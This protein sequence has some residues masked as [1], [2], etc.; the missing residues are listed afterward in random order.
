MQASLLLL[1][2]LSTTPA[3]ASTAVTVLDCIC[4]R[5]FDRGMKVKTN[6]MLDPY[7]LGVYSIVARTRSSCRG[8]L[9]DDAFRSS[10]AML[11]QMVP[12]HNS[13]SPLPSEEGDRCRIVEGMRR[14]E[15]DSAKDLLC[16]VAPEVLD[17]EPD[18][19]LED[20]EWGK[21]L[22]HMSHQQRRHLLDELLV[23]NVQLSKAITSN[24]ECYWWSGNALTYNSS[25]TDSDI[26]ASFRNVLRVLSSSLHKHLQLLSRAMKNFHRIYTAL[27]LQQK[28]KNMSEHQL[29]SLL[30]YVEKLWN[31]LHVRTSGWLED[32][33]DV[34]D[35]LS[36]TL[37]KKRVQETAWEF[38]I[39][40]ALTYDRLLDYHD[41]RTTFWEDFAEKCEKVIGGTPEVLQ[42]ADAV[43]TYLVYKWFRKTRVFFETCYYFVGKDHEWQLEDLS[44]SRMSVDSSCVQFMVDLLDRPVC[45]L[46]DTSEQT[47]RK[48]EACHLQLGRDLMYGL[49]YIP[50]TSY[51]AYT[52][53]VNINI[54][55]LSWMVISSKSV[56]EDVPHRMIKSVREAL[57]IFPH[58]EGK[59]CAANKSLDI[60]CSVSRAVF[61]FK[62][63]KFFSQTVHSTCTLQY[64]YEWNRMEPTLD[65]SSGF[66]HQYYS[67][68]KVTLMEVLSIPTMKYRNFKIEHL[69]SLE[70]SLIS[71]N[72][73]FRCVTAGVYLYLPKLRNLPGKLLLCFQFTGIM[74]ILCSEVAYRMFGVPDL[75]T[76][77]QLDSSL[78]LLSCI[79]LN[80]FCYLVFTGVRHLRLPDDLDACEASRLFRIYV[81]YALSLW[82]VVSSTFVSLERVSEQ[83]LFHSR[84]LLLTAISLS[85]ACNL[86]LFLIVAYTCFR[87]RQSMTKLSVT[88]SKF[89]TRK[90]MLLLSVKTFLLS[91]LGIVARVGFHQAEGVARYVYC[92][93]LATMLQGPAIFVLF[94]CNGSALPQLR[95]RLQRWWSP[96]VI[97]PGEDLCS[98]AR[99]NVGKLR[100]KVEQNVL[101][102]AV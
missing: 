82:T 58:S 40:Y 9:S 67:E 96:D 88:T 51:L 60:V 59:S 44:D 54:C 52:Q 79:W 73:F 43:H 20:V 99:R 18:K 8:A 61:S 90:Q 86:L 10:L 70:V 77:V 72:I 75:A 23:T 92:V 41:R 97:I 21:K 64:S 50:V 13:S 53:R 45:P 31:L 34:I 66:L 29:T 74:Q 19:W 102:T 33:N 85:V 62:C 78:T 95:H 17:S 84:A 49:S 76:T 38:P 2:A 27:I 65:V 32:F 7:C 100:L 63:K 22:L 15:A 39:R 28:G 55:L 56:C 68:R 81:T 80:T 83:Y 24:M 16:Q 98:S 4:D 12:R 35:E 11:A 89:G 36:N 93:H 57:C 91:G 6:G 71:V 30:K 5:F 94:V 46:E 47:L 87:T 69:Q 48:R 3:A 101:E 42:L 14:M 1:V 25:W 26:E 37:L